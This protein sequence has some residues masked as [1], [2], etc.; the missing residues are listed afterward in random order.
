MRK[1]KE[2]F[3]TREW[4]SHN[5][6]FISGC[7]HDC[8]YCYS[9][10]MAIRF[11]RKTP[12]TWKV[13]ELNERKLAAPMKKYSGRVMFPSS[14][15][16][17]PQNLEHS[18]QF[19]KKLLEFGNDVLLVTKPHYECITRIC[20]DFQKYRDKILLRFTIGSPDSRTLKL[21]EPTA[22][23]FAERLKSLKA[24]YNKDFN[25]SI[26]IEPILDK[27]A[28]IIR[29]VEKVEPFVSN[30]IW[31]GKPNFLIRRL[32][33]NGVTSTEILE[34]AATLE[35]WC[36]NEEIMK[37]YSTLKSHR[38]VKWKESIKKVVGIDISTDS[39]LDI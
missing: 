21:W 8:L 4:A 22:P 6:N 16:I 1:K 38:K 26:S 29:L 35:R 31:I 34:K 10:E 15:D 30:A 20:T 19:L 11:K 32:K 5:Q 2:A 14:H 3:G 27:R 36:S 7:L 25:T 23:S 12:E 39:G 28:A 9:K 13:E 33:M 18:V 37:L 24:A 17:T